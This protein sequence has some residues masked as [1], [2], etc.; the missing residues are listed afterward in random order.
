MAHRSIRPR[1]VL[2]VN[3]SREALFAFAQA[4]L[5]PAPGWHTQ[6]AASQGSTSSHDTPVTR[7]GTQP[8]AV[9]TGAEQVVI[10]PNPFYQIYEGAA[11]LAG[12]RLHLVDQRPE[13]GFAPDWQAVPEAIWQKTKLV[14]VCSPGNPTGHV[15]TLDDWKTLLA[16][17]D[18]YG[19]IIASD[20]CYSEIYRDENAPPLGALAVC[21]QLGRPDYRQVVVFSSLSKRSNVPGMRSGF[22]AGD[23]ALLARFLRYRTYH[24]CAMSP[25]FQQASMAAWKTRRTWPTTGGCTGRSSTR[26]CPSCNRWC[27]PCRRLRQASTCGCRCPVVMT[28]ALPH[29]SSMNGG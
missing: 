20:E 23:A 17:A 9:Q 16:L 11:L 18:R 2:P 29:A 13:N 24:G 5:D 8:A 1:R 27:R 4:M 21:Q 14:Y 6:D 28:S 10:A 7:N 3:G 15:L 22:V 25:M 19:F 12:A 26:C